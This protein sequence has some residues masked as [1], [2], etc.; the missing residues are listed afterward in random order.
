MADQA[1]T[2]FSDAIFVRTSSFWKFAKWGSAYNSTLVNGDYDATLT[3]NG[4]K[5]RNLACSGSLMA[6]SL[7]VYASA[8][9]AM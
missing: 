8:S 1:L 6:A 7:P 2:A 3:Q 9:Y 4:Y 5:P